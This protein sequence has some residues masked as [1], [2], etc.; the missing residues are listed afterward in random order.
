VLLYIHTNTRGTPRQRTAWCACPKITHFQ[1][2][3]TRK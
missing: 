1:D 3:A 2:A